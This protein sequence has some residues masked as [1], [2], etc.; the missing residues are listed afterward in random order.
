MSY[1]ANYALSFSDAGQMKIK[2]YQSDTF[3]QEMET[4]WQGL[5]PLY[6][7]VT[8][9]YDIYNI[10]ISILSTQTAARLCPAQAAS[11]LW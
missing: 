6:E 9:Y 3:M 5:K 10:S 7:Q 1:D 8:K 4:T 2:A 11:P